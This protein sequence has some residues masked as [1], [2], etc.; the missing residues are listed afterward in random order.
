MVRLRSISS[1][2]PQDMG[3]ALS[4]I[5]LETDWAAA[6]MGN[7][8]PELKN[9]HQDVTGSLPMLGS[10]PAP[11]ILP[12]T[13]RAAVTRHVKKLQER[14]ESPRAAQ[15]RRKKILAGMRVQT[16]VFRREDAS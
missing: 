1:C 10:R 7:A 6:A 13:G 9:R 5:D 11:K 16:L 12:A 4:C 8:H 2:T 15:P 3:A 14:R